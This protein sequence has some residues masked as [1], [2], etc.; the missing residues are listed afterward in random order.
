M[1][2]RIAHIA[3]IEHY[4]RQDDLHF[5]R[6]FGLCFPGDDLV[7]ARYNSSAPPASRVWPAVLQCV[8]KRL[9]FIPH[10]PPGE[11]SN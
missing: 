3:Q 11:S 7:I 10:S 2:A 6:F 9:V 4:V 8:P 1:A 5:C